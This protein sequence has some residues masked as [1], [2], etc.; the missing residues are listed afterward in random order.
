MKKSSRKSGFAKV[1]RICKHYTRLTTKSCP[2]FHISLVTHS[3]TNS[4]V[5]VGNGKA[6][7]RDVSVLEYDVVMVLKRRQSARVGKKSSLTSLIHIYKVNEV[8]F[9]H[10][11]KTDICHF[12]RH[13]VH[14]SYCVIAQPCTYL[15]S[16]RHMTNSTHVSS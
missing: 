13:L 10:R 8:A 1:E 12:Q 3:H 16:T 5:K 14:C 15:Q 7:F 4:A 2:V 6:R 9:N 11:A